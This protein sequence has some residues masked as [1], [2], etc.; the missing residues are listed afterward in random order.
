MSTVGELK[1]EVLITR[2]NVNIDCFKNKYVGEKVLSPEFDIFNSDKCKN[3]FRL[4]LYPKGNSRNDTGFISLFLVNLSEQKVCLTLSLSL[5]NQDNTKVDYS[6]VLEDCVFDTKNTSWGNSHFYPEKFIMDSKKKILKDNKC[7]I[8]CKIIVKDEIKLEEVK[9]PC[10]NNICRFKEFDSFEKLLTNEEFS[11]ITIVAEGKSFKLHKCILS[12]R[13]N[14]FE[15]MFRNDMVEKNQG[16][17]QIEDIRHEVLQELFQFVYTGK[18]N[19]ITS[20]ADDL[21]IAAEKYNIDGLKA[22]CEK[23]MCDNLSEANALKY[24]KLAVTNN[25]QLLKSKTVNWIWLRLE[26]FIKKPE[27]NELGMEHPEVLLEIIKKN[28]II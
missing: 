7:S 12:T 18:V 17:V 24:L 21:L 28:F 23:T 14:V 13:S 10:S 8:L 2:W 11:D 1:K 15:A 19:R 5:L 6:K 20:I 22:L 16:T 25:A 4:E 27:F 3:K 26:G 9:M